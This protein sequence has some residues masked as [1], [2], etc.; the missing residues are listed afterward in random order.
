MNTP[1]R[2]LLM[3]ACSLGLHAVLFCLFSIPIPKEATLKEATQAKEAFSLVH[4]TLREPAAPA[5][6]PKTP[7]PP[8]PPEPRPVPEAETPESYYEQAEATET[9]PEPPAQ[10]TGPAEVAQRALGSVEKPPPKADA[11]AYMKRNYRYLQQRIRDKL[12]YPA[13]ARREGIQGTTQ[14]AFTIHEDGRVSAVQV[15]KT[16]GHPVLDQAAVETIYAAAPFPRP[17]APARIA[18]PIAFKLR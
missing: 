3:L 1:F 9:S 17:P 7:P 4:L 13:K 8:R 2:F 10:G 18:I 15:L 5:P 6:L 14:V 16:S 11:E 12:V